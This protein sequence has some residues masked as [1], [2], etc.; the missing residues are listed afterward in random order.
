MILLKTN[1][2]KR[3]YF[4][5]MDMGVSVVHLASSTASFNDGL[6]M[7]LLMNFWPMIDCFWV[8]WVQ[9][10]CGLNDYWCILVVWRPFLLLCFGL[11]VANS[12]AVVRL[13]SRL[14]GRIQREIECSWYRLS[15]VWGRW[16]SVYSVFAICVVQCMFFWKVT[17]RNLVVL[18]WHEVW[19]LWFLCFLAGASS[20]EDTFSIWWIQL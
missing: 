15:T 19:D 16:G 18:F 12:C 8:M 20:K 17:P 7:V 1:F 9:I 2:I 3:L 10:C 13:L 11:S 5:F 14:V 4:S 6:W